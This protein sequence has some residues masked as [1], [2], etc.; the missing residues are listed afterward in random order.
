MRLNFNTKKYDFDNF[1]KDNVFGNIYYLLDGEIGKIEIICWKNHKCYIIN[2]AIKNN[3][4][5]INK[6]EYKA[7]TGRVTLYKKT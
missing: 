7:E 4:L 3:E 1:S 5:C 2:C 6:V